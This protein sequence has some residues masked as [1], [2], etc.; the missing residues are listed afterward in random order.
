MLRVFSEQGSQ[1][2]LWGSGSKG[3]SFLTIMKATANIDYVVDINPCRQGHFMS[4]T[5]QEIVSP[6]FLVE[7]RPDVVIVMNA[8]YIEEIGRKIQEL[9]LSP[10][11]ISLR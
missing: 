4:G 8:I 3:V 2:V 10:E 1:V 7:Y 6:E 11:I 5:G 9:N